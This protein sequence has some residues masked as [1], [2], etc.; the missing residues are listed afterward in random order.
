LHF[1][2]YRSDYCCFVIVVYFIVVPCYCDA[3]LSL[4]IFFVVY[5]LLFILFLSIL[6]LFILII[7]ILLLFIVIVIVNL[8]Y[9]SLLLQYEIGATPACN[10]TQEQPDLWENPL[11]ISYQ[12]IGFSKFSNSLGGITDAV[13]RHRPDVLFLE[14]LGVPRKKAGK[15]RQTLERKLGDE[16][17]LPTNTSPPRKNCLSTGIAAVIHC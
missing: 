10:T 4:F 16:W 12:N 6:L 9:C 3:L 17:F 8:Q 13:L 14:D 1:C 15:L 5:L 11:M 7:S 2:E